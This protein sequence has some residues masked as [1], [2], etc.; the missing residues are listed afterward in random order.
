[1]DC[2]YGDAAACIQTNDVGVF[3]GVGFG[4]QIVVVH[5]ALDL[6]IV[7]RDAGGTAFLTTP[8]DRIRPAPVAHDPQYPGDDDAFCAA[9]SSGNYAPDLHFMP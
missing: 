9:Y 6:V 4:G 3:G 1:M 2:N 8:W 7:T 5:K